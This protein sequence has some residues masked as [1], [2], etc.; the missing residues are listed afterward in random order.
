MLRFPSGRRLSRQLLQVPS[1]LTPVLETGSCR[2]E[3]CQPALF[4]SLKQ[5]SKVT[6]VSSVKMFSNRET[7]PRCK[8]PTKTCQK[9]LYCFC[10][11]HFTSFIGARSYSLHTLRESTFVATTERGEAT[12]QWLVVQMKHL[13]FVASSQQSPGIMI[14]H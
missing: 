13:C 1:G 14:I 3:L 5:L 6:A 10:E 2:L 4:T 8:E 11:P 12:N 9:T 7:M